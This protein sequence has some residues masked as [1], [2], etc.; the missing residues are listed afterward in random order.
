MKCSNKWAVVQLA[1]SD[2][3]GTADIYSRAINCN[4]YDDKELTLCRL[5][6]HHELGVV[7]TA[8]ESPSSIPE[9]GRV[10]C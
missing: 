2:K 8:E 9:D 10:G 7:D 6:D 4:G 3:E 5:A 1:T